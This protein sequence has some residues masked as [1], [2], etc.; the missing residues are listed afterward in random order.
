MNTSNQTRRFFL[1]KSSASL[2][3]LSLATSGPA[4]VP[5]SVLGQNPPSDKVVVGIIGLGWRGNDLLREC[6]KNE[7]IQI[8]ALADLDLAFLM[9]R[10]EFVDTH[11]GAERKWILG[12]AWDTLPA[13][14]P[15]GAPEPYLDYRRLL[16]RS[17]ID[18][19]LA[20]VPDH[21]HARVYLDAMDAGKDVYG[22]KPLAL[23]IKQGRKVVQ[24]SV[25]SGRLFQIGLQ[26]RSHYHFQRA[27]ELVRNGR[28]GKLNKI[29]VIIRGTP[30]REPVPDAP[31]PG[32]LNWDMWL[33]QAPV[34]PYNPLRCHVFFRYFFEYSGGQITDL[35][36]HHADIAQW[37]L[38]MDNSGPQFIEGTTRVKPGAFNTFTD[39]NL[40]LTYA[41]GE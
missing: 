17:D 36:A 37:A 14:V 41:N 24:K 22:E 16:E 7:H 9:G 11:L 4:W 30:H 28:L 20:A 1:K 5:A 13:P 8:A 10:M 23:T 25:D 15:T 31:P 18:A 27:C 33:G 38:D 2:A 6:I 32:T 35:G 3:W 34:V 29:R 26:Q 39:Y 40:A 21:W 12:S 19:V